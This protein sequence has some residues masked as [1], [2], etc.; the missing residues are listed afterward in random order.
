[1]RLVAGDP[2]WVFA[3]VTAKGQE[4]AARDRRQGSEPVGWVA[5]D[6]VHAMFSFG[7]GLYAQFASKAALPYPPADRCGL[8]I[9]GSKGAIFINLGN[10][11]TG[12]GFLLRSPYW[13][14]RPGKEQWQPLPS[15]GP[16]RE[17]NFDRANNAVALDLLAAIEQDREPFC[18]ARDG[19]WTIE[20]IAGVYQSHKMGRRV[21]FPLT[22]RRD[23]LES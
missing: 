9:C 7:K 19:R 13:M 15:P 2:A 16:E 17:G 18:S 6:S 22:D 11:R 1:M 23:P 14:A 12:D 10:S 8:L 21:N 4:I 5:G 20:M 3:D